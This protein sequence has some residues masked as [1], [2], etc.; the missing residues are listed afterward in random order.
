VLLEN[1]T[2]EHWVGCL[3]HSWADSMGHSWAGWRVDLKEYLMADLK[4]ELTVVLMV[5]YSV[6]N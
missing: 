3:D 5:V 1:P 6:A 2:V 4:V